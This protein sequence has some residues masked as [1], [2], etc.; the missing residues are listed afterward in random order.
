MGFFKKFF[1]FI[2]NDDQVSIS[3]TNNSHDQS[4]ILNTQAKLYPVSDEEKEL[5]SIISSIIVAGNNPTTNIK[6][7]NVFRLDK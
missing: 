3:E 1:S 7:K 6:I 2:N 4:S 5:V